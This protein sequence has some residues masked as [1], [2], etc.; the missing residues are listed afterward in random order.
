MIKNFEQLIT[1]VKQMKNKTVVIAAAHTSSAI[2][3]AIMAKKENI[4]DSLLV[5]DK[6]YID[7]YLHK[8]SPEFENYFMIIDTGEDLELAASESVKA[9]RDGKAEI[10]LKGKCATA[11]LIKAVLNKENGLRTGENLSDV[12]VYEH[13]EKLVLMSDGG[14]NL[15]PGVKEKISIIKNAV[16][17]GHALDNLK[18]KVALLAAVEVVNTKMP[19]TVDANTIKEMY[20][21][22]KIDDCIVEGPIAFDGAVSKM[23][24]KEKGIESEV[25]GDADVLV[26]PNIEAG[27]IFGKALTYYCKYRVAHVV[28]G[29]KVPILI[30]SRVDTA[31]TK[32]LSIAL[33]VL[34]SQ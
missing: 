18:P 12:L 23:A 9:I 16:K 25:G 4:A 11:I 34:S 1:K 15:Y 20:K 24:A 7:K 28:M 27:N 13:P 26:V 14:I 2:D 29:A 22:D 30:A 21:N 33:G 19:A 31:E 5:G 3:A 8:N 17:V 32:M 6:Q 10:L